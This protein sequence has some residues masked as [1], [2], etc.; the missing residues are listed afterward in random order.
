MPGGIGST[1]K[2]LILGKNVGTPALLGCS[3]KVR[4]T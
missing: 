4:V 3:F 2:V 1:H